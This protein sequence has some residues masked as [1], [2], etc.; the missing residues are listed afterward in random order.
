MTWPF[1]IKKGNR[2]LTGSHIGFLEAVLYSSS[3]VNFLDLRLALTSV[4]NVLLGLHNSGREE[5]HATCG[6]INRG[7]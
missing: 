6:L 4:L 2:G 3:A 7:N 5:W 1:G